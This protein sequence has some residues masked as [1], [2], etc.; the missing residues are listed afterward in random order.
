MSA[1]ILATFLA[2]PASP[3]DARPSVQEVLKE[4]GPAIRAL[5]GVIDVAVGGTAEDP[6][7]MVRVSSEEAK[8]A[9]SQKIGG[10]AGGYKFYIYVAGP[11]GQT[12]VAPASSTETAK[13]PPPRK[14]ETEKDPETIEDCDIFRD[15]LKLKPVVRHKD[16]LTIDGCKLM[17]R[18]RVGG[19]GGHAFWYTR[20]RF[21][22]PLRTNRLTI[23]AKAD[24]FTT[25]VF[26]RGFQPASEGSFL[27]FELKGSDKL[28]FDGVKDD[29]TALLPY[30]REGARWVK[31]DK[32]DAGVGWKWEVRKE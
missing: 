3:Q 5:E 20:H 30:I 23:P 29:L 10:H 11:A 25:W 32:E 22:C 19:G 16:K 12:V 31:A 28:W 6:R 17:R 21:D 9:V 24:E 1:L 27:V 2:I 8:A 15:H 14:T 26:T 4:Q 13:P 18:S 7:I